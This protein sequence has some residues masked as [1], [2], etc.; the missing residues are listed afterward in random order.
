[1]DFTSLFSKRARD[2][3]KP[4]LE[5]MRDAYLA[6]GQP[7]VDIPSF[8]VGGTNGKGSTSGFLWRLLSVAGLRTGLYSSPHLVAFCERMQI[9]DQSIDDADLIRCWEELRERLGLERYERLSFFELTTLMG[10][11]IFADRQVAAQVLEVGMG[12]RWDATNVVEPLAS[13][14]VSVSRDHQDYL[15]HQLTGI[16]QEKLGIIRPGR[17]V[18]WGS[19]GEAEHDPECRDILQRTVREKD[20]PLYRLGEH[21]GVTASEIWLNLPELSPIR[22]TYQLPSRAR[23]LQNNLALACAVYHWYQSQVMR[24]LPS[25][26]QLMD[27]FVH[28]PGALAPTLMGRLTALS[29]RLPQRQQSVILDVCHNIDGLKTMLDGLSAVGLESTRKYPALVSILRDKDFVPMLQILQGFFEPIVLFKIPSDRTWQAEDMAGLPSSLPLCES[30]AAAWQYMNALRP[31][32]DKP[33][34]ICGSV[35][36]AGKVL[37]YFGLQPRTLHWFD[38]WYH[39]P[40]GVDSPAPSA[41]RERL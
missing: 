32:D 7:G 4:G 27:D 26:T 33:W 8:I 24:Q 25:I 31:D 21:F 28:A 36:A 15:G 16:L 19:G 9:S 34:V 12:G 37:E 20:C 40:I 14:I 39:Q 35:L 1:M 17:P 5:R 2:L 11:Q 18:F 29:V 38:H 3:I 22:M 13:V 6:L 10:L 41:A 30:F 23:F